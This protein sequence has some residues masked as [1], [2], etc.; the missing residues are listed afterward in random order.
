MPYARDT[1]TQ[2]RSMVLA[3]IA[4]R[5][6]G[7]NPFQR[8]T[9]L[10]VF[11]TVYAGQL[12]DQFGYLDWIAKN[13]VPFTAT[14]EYLIGWAALRGVTLK[15]ATGSSGPVIFTGAAGAPVYG[16]QQVALGQQLFAVTDGG[17][18]G[19]DGTGTFNI[20]ALATGAAGNLAPGAILNLVTP[21][22]GIVSVA[23]VAGPVGLAGGADLETLDSL[24]TRML[25]VYAAP[26]QGGD[27]NDYALW[28]LAVPGVTRAWGYSGAGAG[29]VVV[30][31]MMDDVRAQESGIPQGKNGTSQY[32]TRGAAP[33]SGDQLIVAD[34]LY[35]KRAASALVYASAPAPVPLALTLSEVPSDQAIRDGIAAAVAG[36]LRREA[37][38]GG[39]WITQTLADG[40]TLQA[41]GGI[42][43]L[44]HIEDAIAATP[45]LDYFLIVAPT[46]D[47][48]VGLGE[49]SIPGPIA[50]L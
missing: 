22:E 7:S 46:T 14:G 39:V 10:N 32:E 29:S 44:S 30:Y 28:A 19:G 12:D 33:A 24:R 13:G 4:T 3:E 35:P 27:L 47:I 43:R 8:R 21:S 49:I 11:G 18:L 16:A 17:T 26:P 5:L 23:T 45:G 31:F 2:L 34:Q 48:A 9:A 15:P 1:L 41:P 36:V 6:P 40:S 42:V 25:A 38:P 50:Y 20:A 37:A